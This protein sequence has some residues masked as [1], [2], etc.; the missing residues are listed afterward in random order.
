MF[1]VLIWDY[2]GTSRKWLEQ[3]A[4]IK[5]IEFVG[6]ITPSKPTPEILLKQ[7]AWDWLLIFEQGMRN[8]FD[9]TIQVLKLPL[10][11]V[12]YALDIQSWLQ[13]PKAVYT[14]LN[15]VGGACFIAT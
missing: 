2:T 9:A 4:E 12:V 5:D 13:R 8:F 1:K 15:A 7:N 10:D 11:K 3:F 6:A 14:L